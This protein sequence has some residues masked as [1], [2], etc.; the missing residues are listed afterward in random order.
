MVSAEHERQATPAERTSIRQLIAERPVMQALRMGYHVR[1]EAEALDLLD[2]IHLFAPDRIYAGLAGSRRVGKIAHS[3]EKILRKFKGDMP[4]KIIR[5]IVK[6]WPQ[7]A[8]TADGRLP[9]ELPGIRHFELSWRPA[10]QFFYDLDAVVVP[11][12]FDAESIYQSQPG[13]RS[14]TRMDIFIVSQQKI[15][16]PGSVFY[17]PAFFNSERLPYLYSKTRGQADYRRLF[18]DWRKKV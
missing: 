14:G 17:A 5:E 7:V 10:N 13:A 12:Q 9:L 4:L 18:R 2:L 11:K 1:N 6:A 16:E 15:L 8:A 3:E